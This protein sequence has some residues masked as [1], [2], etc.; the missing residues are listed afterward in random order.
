[1]NGKQK[2]R[3]HRSLVGGLYAKVGGSPKVQLKRT[4]AEECK[5]RR[6]ALL[7]RREARRSRSLCVKRPRGLDSFS[8]L[9]PWLGVE[10]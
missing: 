5:K 2:R 6:H 1:M 4:S 3:A 7:P 10:A 9:G 8:L